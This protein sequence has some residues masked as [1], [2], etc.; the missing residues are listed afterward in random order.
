MNHSHELK[1]NAVVTAEIE[2]QRGRASSSNQT[3]SRV[4]PL[5][6]SDVCG[7]HLP[8]RNFSRRKNTQHAARLQPRERGPKCLPVGFCGTIRVKGIHEDAVLLQFRNIPEKK[9]S[10]NLHV[11]ADAGKNLRQNRA[12]Q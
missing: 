2:W 8:M 1:T 11:G 4:T 6:I 5:R 7:W 9:I 10:Q 12:V 3:H